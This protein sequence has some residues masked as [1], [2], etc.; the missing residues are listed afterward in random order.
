L[1]AI[2]VKEKAKKKNTRTTED[3]KRRVREKK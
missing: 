1:V 2:G 3:E